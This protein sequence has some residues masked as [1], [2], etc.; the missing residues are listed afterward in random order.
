MSDAAR[1]CRSTDS[2][3]CLSPGRRL[4][5][6]CCDEVSFAIAPRRGLRAGRRI[7]LRQVDGRLSAP[8]LS[9]SR[10]RRID[11]GRVLFKGAGSAAA[12]AARRSTG[13]A[14]TASASCRRI[15]PRRSSPGMR[16][17]DQVAEV[18]RGHGARAT[19]RRRRPRVRRAVRPGRPAGARAR[20]AERY[21][22]QLSG[23]QQQRVVHRHGAGLRARS[24]WCSTS[25]PPASTSR[26]RSRS[27]SC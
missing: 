23:G 5:A 27:S 25:R 15:R 21:P 2:S 24:A 14:A 26:R 7:R 22:H 9:P 11:G 10:R 20:S 8:G 1:C 17:G 12:G 16:V 19:G 13:C 3:V 6:R 4:A 18:L